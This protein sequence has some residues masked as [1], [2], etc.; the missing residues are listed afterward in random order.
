MKRSLVLLSL[1]TLG[2]AACD[3]GTVEPL[4]DTLDL[5]FTGL[6]PLTNGFHYEGWAII[7]GA[8]ISTGKFNVDGSGGLTTVAGAPIPGGRFV[9]G[10]DLMNTTTIVLTIEPSGDT[11]TTPADTHVLAG[12]ISAGSAPLTADHGAALGADFTTATG[13]YILATPTDG[14]MNNENSGI[15]FLSLASGAPAVGLDLPTLPAGW[16]YEGWVVIDGQPVTTGRFTA[17]DMVDDAAPFSSTMG[18][19]PFPGE[20][21]LVNAP[22]GLTFP[23]DIAGGTAVISIEPHPDDSDAPYTFKPLMGGIDAA[24]MDHVTYMLPNMTTATF[25][26]GTATIR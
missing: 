25:P 3:N 17:V 22:A 1:A 4:M 8:P 20:D 2:I 14:A 13:D 10:T 15:W 24:A 9:T 23:T 5:S 19:P 18:G 16:A 12:S 6:D 7:D 11:D 21:F 26:T